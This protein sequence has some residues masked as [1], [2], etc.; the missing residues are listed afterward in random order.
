MKRQSAAVQLRTSRSLTLQS[1]LL[2]LARHKTRIGMCHMTHKRVGASCA[3]VPA[4]G[5]VTP[6]QSFQPTSHSS[7]RS[8][9]AAAELHRWASGTRT[10]GGRV[11]SHR[12]S[13]IGS[14]PADACAVASIS[15]E[16][17]V[18]Q[19]SPADLPVIALVLEEK[20]GSKASPV[21]L[22]V[23]VLTRMQ[24]RLHR[25]Q[26]QQP[27]VASAQVGASSAPGKCCSLTPNQSFQP[28]SHSSLRSSRAAAELQRW[29]SLLPRSYLSDTIWP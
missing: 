12:M 14:S 9:C 21:D 23:C 3:S 20:T 28:T 29:A 7:L 8:S 24:R 13:A 18:V 5:R 26:L 19:A 27:R 10:S 22:H 16:K 4:H 2:R 17:T 25:A 6:N 1:V 15:E 11:P